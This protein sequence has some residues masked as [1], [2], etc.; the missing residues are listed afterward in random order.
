MIVAREPSGDLGP[1]AC[2]HLSPRVRCRGLSGAL[3]STSCLE[4]S[5]SILVKGTVILEHK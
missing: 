4:C 1:V 2:D 5:L 3:T